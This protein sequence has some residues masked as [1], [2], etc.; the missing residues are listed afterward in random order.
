MFHTITVVST[1]ES[2]STDPS[3]YNRR[4]V[5]GT[6]VSYLNFLSKMNG[7]SILIEGGG[8]RANFAIFP[9]SV[10]R[11][12]NTFIPVLYLPFRDIF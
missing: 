7:R 10:W 5:L 4:E 6:V 1:D 3:N 8:G 9:L 12:N 2:G 11:Q